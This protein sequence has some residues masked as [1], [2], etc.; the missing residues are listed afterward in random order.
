M[1]LSELHIS[2]SLTE[3]ILFQDIP[4]IRL[5]GKKFP[6]AFEEIAQLLSTHRGIVIMGYCP[7]HDYVALEGGKILEN[8]RIY[9]IDIPIPPLLMEEKLQQIVIKIELSELHISSTGSK[10]P[11]SKP[12]MGK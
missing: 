9:F 12:L 10:P 11:N 1:E 6:E 2:K 8:A 3:Q 4:V 5:D 7:K